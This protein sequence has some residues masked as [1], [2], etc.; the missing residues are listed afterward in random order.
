MSSIRGM[1][2]KEFDDY[3]KRCGVMK[4]L[5]LQEY[6]DH[7]FEFSR[8]RNLYVEV[9]INNRSNIL[10]LPDS[11][12]KEVKRHIATKIERQSGGHG[13]C[14]ICFE[15][16]KKD[17]SCTKCAS[18]WCGECYIDLFRTG[19]GII[20]CPYCRYSWGSATP[21]DMIPICIN[22]IRQKLARRHS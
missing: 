13:D 14:N 11:T 4:N 10:L 18:S 8:N 7:E 12:W 19:R 6:T 17:V 16:I 21:D 15:K 20:T 22:E 9:L 2:Q 5:I 1:T 3:D